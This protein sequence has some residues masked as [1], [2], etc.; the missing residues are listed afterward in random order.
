MYAEIAVLTKQI[1]KELLSGKSDTEPLL[2]DLK[3]DPYEDRDIADKYPEVVTEMLTRIAE[4]KNTGFDE[5]CNW[6]VTD[7]KVEHEKVTYFDPITKSNK[8]VE[9]HGPWVDDDDWENYSP[10]EWNML[11]L[12]MRTAYAIVIGEILITVFIMSRITRS[13]FL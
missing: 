10:D 1:W 8:T 12:R 3:N 2:F 9:F 11:P 7:T 5:P 6:W 4:M 13:I